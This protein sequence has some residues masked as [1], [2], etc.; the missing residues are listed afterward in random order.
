MFSNE[1][2]HIKT[3]ELEKTVW[4][5]YYEEYIRRDMGAV[6]ISST[7]WYILWQVFNRMADEQYYP[8]SLPKVDLVKVLSKTSKVCV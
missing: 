4:N 5:E 6:G 2:L 3:D 8:P 7:V 1:P